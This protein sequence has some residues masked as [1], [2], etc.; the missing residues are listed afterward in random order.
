MWRSSTT[1]VAPQLVGADDLPIS[2]DL[3]EAWWEAWWGFAKE[4]A[5]ARYQYG[6][7]MYTDSS[8]PIILM[9]LCERA[10]DPRATLGSTLQYSKAE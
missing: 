1:R 9:A 5:P 3:R 4:S 10:R 6:P 8:K 2:F 7:C